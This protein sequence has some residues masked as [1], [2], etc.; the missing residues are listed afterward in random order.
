MSEAKHIPGPWYCDQSDTKHDFPTRREIFGGG[1]LIAE[2]TGNGNGTSGANARLIAAS[3]QLL[4]ACLA[5][6][7][8][9][10]RSERGPLDSATL[11]EILDAAIASATKS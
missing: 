11:C 7:E 1:Y 4:H 2:V 9:I 3:P 5:A 6:V 8:F 10:T